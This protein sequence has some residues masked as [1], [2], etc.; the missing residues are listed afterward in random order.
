MN[1]EILENLKS[2]ILDAIGLLG[3]LEIKATQNNILIM[4]NSVGRINYVL[5]EIELELEK[6][7]NETK[8]Q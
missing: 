2:N 7:E 5:N 6:C 3:Q 4:Y 1:K 8:H